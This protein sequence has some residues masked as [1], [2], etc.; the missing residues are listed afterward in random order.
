[1]TALIA[2]SLVALVVR[3]FS[4]NQPNWRSFYAVPI[5]LICLAQNV[6]YVS[7]YDRLRRSSLEQG[8]M[9][10]SVTG[11]DAHLFTCAMVL[12][13]PELFYYAGLPTHA[14]DG[15]NLDW[16][17]VK[18]GSWVVLEPQELEIWQHDVPNRLKRV[19]PFVANKNPGDLVWYADDSTTT[20]P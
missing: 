18:L 10:R 4:R 3:A 13:Q 7:H 6:G 17:D 16:H 5:I 11:P 15:D 20:S 2:I 8:K 14:F 19:I 12:D 9:I 1:M